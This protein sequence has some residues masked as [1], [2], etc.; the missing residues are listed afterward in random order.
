MRRIVAIALVAAA[1]CS[2]GANTT[3]KGTQPQASDQGVVLDDEAVL[4]KRQWNNPKYYV[5]DKP[6][7]RK[8]KQWQRACEELNK[9]SNSQSVPSYMEPYMAANLAYTDWVQVCCSSLGQDL[10]YSDGYDFLLWRMNE[11]LP[12]TGDFEGETERYAFFR[13]QADTL[14]NCWTSG[15]QWD[16]YFKADLSAR[17][18]DI[19]GEI[20]SARLR[21]VLPSMGRVLEME[22]QAYDSFYTA[23]YK[24]FEKTQMDPDGWDGSAASMAYSDMSKEL[25]GPR[26]R[27]II[28]FYLAITDPENAPE[29]DRHAI[30]TD[31]MLSDEY[32]AF[33]ESLEPMDGRYPLDEQQTALKAE[34]AAWDKWMEVRQTVSGSLS[35]TEKEIWDNCTNNLK[36]SHLISLKNRYEGMGIWSDSELEKL[37]RE[38]CS[39]RILF[40]DRYDAVN[41]HAGR[42]P[43]VFPQPDGL[44]ADFDSLASFVS[45]TV[46]L[47][48]SL[49]KAR[50]AIENAD[51]LGLRPILMLRGREYDLFPHNSTA[52]Y[53]LSISLLDLD[54]DG[55]MEL[56]VQDGELFSLTVY[57][58]TNLPKG[59]PKV[60]GVMVCNNGFWL[61][62]D[63]VL[64]ARLGTQ[65]IA[66]SACLI[67]GRL[68]IQEEDYIDKLMFSSKEYSNLKY[69]FDDTVDQDRT[70]SRIYQADDY[71]LCDQ[72]SIIGDHAFSLDLD[73]DGLKE[74]LYLGRPTWGIQVIDIMRVILPGTK[75]SY[76]LASDIFASGDKTLYESDGLDMNFKGT[77]QLSAKDVNGDGRKEIVAT[78][79]DNGKYTNFVWSFDRENGTHLISKAL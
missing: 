79:G 9:S 35:G 71:I 23:A 27:S 55:L 76:D 65:G 25:A 34:R 73:G 54:G 30:I 66:S 3:Q 26:N 61:T 57:G 15:A 72:G 21:R 42:N 40:G 75:T 44:E 4:F 68:R 48:G 43:F 28:P 20:Y 39:D 22:K 2:C 59:E 1:L 45:R 6:S 52:C 53:Y 12:P 63:G 16:Y 64:V 69:V 51:S 50:I 14:E 8:I 18:V 11:L 77:V 10:G 47:G 60:L 19:E 62:D 37:L 17:L 33:L 36:R 78:L 56:L 67:N 70:L 7:A 32:E 58:L 24:T 13:R 31:E 41:N 38:S 5:F 29:E 74:Q 49:G 46:D